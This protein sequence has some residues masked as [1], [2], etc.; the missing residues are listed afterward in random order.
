MVQPVVAAAQ[1]AVQAVAALEDE[2]PVVAAAQLAMQAVAALED[3]RP[4]LLASMTNL[5]REAVENIAAPQSV[6]ARQYFAG[7]L[8]LR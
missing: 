2:R 3:E 1:L 8:Q 5:Q 4:V 7:V 6:R